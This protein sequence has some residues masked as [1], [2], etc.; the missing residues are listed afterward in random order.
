MEDL[1]RRSLECGIQVDAYATTVAALSIEW[2]GLAPTAIVP[3]R[4]CGIP[5]PGRL[6][7]G[8]RVSSFGVLG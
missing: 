3:S 5:G 4:S 8:T 7:E 2:W 1:K 6:V